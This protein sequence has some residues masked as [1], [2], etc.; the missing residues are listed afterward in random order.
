[1]IGKLIKG[2]NPRGLCA[3][4]LG[5][6]DHNGDARPRADIIGGTMAGQTVRDLADEFEALHRLRPRL[7]VHIVHMSLR[8]PEDE[9]P[10]SDEDWRIIGQHWAEGM[11]FDAYVLVSHGDH[12]HIAASRVRA[13]G[14]VVDDAQDFR[15]SEAVIRNI[16]R[17]VGLQR[18]EVSHLLEPS[19]A[20]THRKA[21]GQAEIALAER[22][23]A[24][25]VEQLRDLVQAAL[26]GG[27]T[28]SEFLARLEA[29]GVVVHPNV[30]STGKLNGFAYSLDGRPVTAAALGRGFTLGNMKKQGLSYEPD[31]DLAA[32][33]RA[34]ARATPG[35]FGA[36]DAAPPGDGENRR[37]PDPD[38]DGNADAQRR[39]SRPPVPAP[40]RVHR[41]PDRGNAPDDD[42]DRRKDSVPRQAQRRGHAGGD[43]GG[44]DG[45]RPR[46]AVFR[47]AGRAAFPPVDVPRGHPAAAFPLAARPGDDGDHRGGGGVVGV[48]GAAAVD[49]QAFKARLW[50]SIYD[51]TLPADL[52][53]AL[54]FVD[55][56]RRIVRLVDGAQVEDHGDRITTDRTTP[57][58]AR[59][60]IAEAKAKGWTAVR[61]T[62]SDDFKAL[63]WLEA[64]RQGVP[65]VDW[66]PPADVHATW[67]V[68]QAA[69]TGSTQKEDRMSNPIPIAP[70]VRRLATLSGRPSPQTD[71]TLEQVRAQ[72]AAFDVDG[73]EVQPMPPKGSPLSVERIR[74]W[75][76]DQIE[77]PKTIA[78]LKR[79]NAMGYDIFVRPAP[80]ADGMAA[81]FAF[82]DDLDAEQV[83]RMEADGLPFA[84]RI[85]SSPGRYHGWV[86]LGDVPLD[87]DEVT[88]AARVLADRYGGDPAST[89]WRHYGRLA[90]FTNQKPA[91]KQANG[92]QPWAMLRAASKDVA[93][94][95]ED[96]LAEARER[97]DWA[98]RAKRRA[99]KNRVPSQMPN[100]RRSDDPAHIAASVRSRTGGTDQS[101][102]GRDF[103]AAL[104]LLRRGF[105]EDEVRAALLEASLDLVK[106][107]HRDPESYIAK[108]VIKA[109]EVIRATPLPP[110]TRPGYRMPR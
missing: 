76:A 70:A 77:A 26:E 66:D 50:S 27:S 37:Q 101:G 79:M 17:D 53:A 4:L 89:D 106:R 107:G 74:R 71:R 12:I 1:M 87:R 75:T 24:P 61:L 10:L 83:A 19:R 28:V 40:G 67:E 80:P 49:P 102:S 46:P 36:A 90:G 18:V 6:R 93:P 100:Y 5:R 31:R 82:V 68:E 22:G 30:A 98:E 84:V 85:E 25:V 8:V 63:A 110:G 58:T 52:V 23:A 13:D 32:L 29:A 104:S 86:R 94:S 15:R 34:G 14:G 105:S 45:S 109:A 96:V 43:G 73:F 51:N 44:A 2:R 95:A 72:L 35:T 16:E 59:L 92:R 33:H 38:L 3:Y 65:V 81:P 60:V 11:G 108:T 88:A 55:T 39:G 9:R 42:H 41:R 64:Q 99:P 62:G 91:R 57:A 20:V 54:R 97:L 103:A 7:G 69:R 48:A 78:W 47:P 21:P 56:G